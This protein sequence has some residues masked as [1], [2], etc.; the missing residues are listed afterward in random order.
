M[1]LRTEELG[2]SMVR[3]LQTISG[4]LQRPPGA[5]IWLDLFFACCSLWTVS[6]ALESSCEHQRY[7]AAA[8]QCCARAPSDS[9]RCGVFGVMDI[10]L[11]MLLVTTCMCSAATGMSW[12]L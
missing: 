5:D 2:E 10:G 6:F 3:F 11:G 1:R 8:P 9:R 12:E 7:R 4:L